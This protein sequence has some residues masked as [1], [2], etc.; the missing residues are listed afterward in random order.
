MPGRLTHGAHHQ[1]Q[2][3]DCGSE[4]RA[5]PAE[6][7]HDAE[8]RLEP[9]ADRPGASEQD[10]QQPARHDRR[11]DQRQVHQRIE[12]DRARE[13]ASGEQPGERVGERQGQRDSEQADAERERDDAPLIRHE[14]ACHSAIPNPWRA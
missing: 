6:H 11:H 12:Q 13:T 9:G 3:H 14:P 8:L 4:R 1:R 7:Q 5:G 10:Q 2:G